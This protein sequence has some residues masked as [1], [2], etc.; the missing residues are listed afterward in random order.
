MKK[1][2]G[3]KVCSIVLSA[4]I[5]ASAIP[6]V[7]VSAAEKE[8]I[9]S[10]DAGGNGTVSVADAIKIMKYSLKIE[11]LDVRQKAAAD[12][13][14]NGIGLNS[15]AIVQK[16]CL[17]YD[18]ELPI[19]SVLDEGEDGIIISEKTALIK[20]SEGKQTTESKELYYSTKYNDIPFVSVT[21]SLEIY[22]SLFKKSDFEL[23]TSN[24][25]NSV[26]CTTNHGATVEV[27]YPG[28][29]I[30]FNDYDQFTVNKDYPG[31]TIY[32]ETYKTEL[33]GENDF[34][35]A[36]KYDY[37]YKG[38]PLTINLEDYSVPILKKDNELYLPLATINDIFIS[39]SYN[40]YVFNGENL[41]IVNQNIIADRGCETSKLYYSAEPKDF[42]SEEMT[43][44]NYNELC[45]N[46]DLH[47]GLKEK[48]KIKDFDSY[49]ARMGLKEEYLSGDLLRI[50]RANFELQ[51]V[52]F[53][54]FHSAITAFSPY[55]ASDKAVTLSQGVAYNKVYIERM[56]KI[57]LSKSVRGSYIESV[58]PYERRGDTV[59][60]TFDAFVKKDNVDDYYNKSED[61]TPDLT[62]TVEL[63]SYSLEK[64]KNE[65][66]DVKNVVIDISCNTGGDSHACGFAMDAVLGTGD[67]NVF[68]PITN[69]LHQ[70]STKFDLTLD[71]VIDENDVSM[72]ELGKNIAIITS[73]IS[74]SCGNLFP[75][76][77]KSR[78]NDVIIMGQ[79]SGGGACAVGHIA[80]ASGSFAQISSTYQMVTMK[81]GSIQDID[82]GVA[83]DIYLTTNR[84]YD[85]D[86]ISAI[87]AE[88]FAN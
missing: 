52:C 33:T 11:D 63:F 73:D 24:D 10:G 67:I 29:Y 68:N 82:N 27:N 40:Q 87:V 77:I 55:L 22:K 64:L 42:L 2:F 85:R 48:H 8:P 1:K 21:D 81:N 23:N 3:K 14:G 57:A 78:D 44:L 19:G 53:A 25:G 37:Y 79:T 59:Y 60:I 61:Y 50:E 72:K 9:I 15:A 20:N 84:M 26:N 6:A 16:Y 54:D 17:G 75:V 49:F 62:D 12:V 88:Q 51:T 43:A 58:E 32:D 35:V 4:V 56:Q 76:A 70:N 36:G 18:T 46:L 41:F 83:P 71:G 38:D 13:T 45:L 86:Y 65:D 34:M 31:L 7:T 69:A 66:S 39:P 74:F 5:L 47:Y 30:R 28:K 80:T